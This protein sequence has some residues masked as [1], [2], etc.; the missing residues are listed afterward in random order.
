MK[1]IES[2]KES[3]HFNNLKKNCIKILIVNIYR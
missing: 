2:A 3:T 1:N